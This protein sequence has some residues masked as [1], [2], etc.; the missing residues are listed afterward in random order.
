MR[1]YI[2]RHGH[3]PSLAEAGVK[4]DPERPISARGRAAVRAA[5]LHLNA[6]GARPRLALTSPLKRAIQTSEE[7]LA[8]LKPAPPLKVYEPL[9][10]RVS[11]LELFQAVARDHGAQPEVLLVGHQPQLGELALRLTGEAVELDPGGLV[12]LEAD[13]SGASAR[14][15]WS[16][17]PE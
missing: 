6:Q 16:K 13:R 7:V 1:L 4:T 9:S 5:A 17:S 15:L 3:S 12:A 2:L 14:L 11:G 8:A 10:N